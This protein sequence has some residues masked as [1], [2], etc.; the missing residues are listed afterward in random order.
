MPARPLSTFVLVFALALS[1]SA[2]RAADE[3]APR[4]IAPPS[5]AS[6]AAHDDRPISAPSGS[7]SADAI[8]TGAALVGVLALA[9]ILKK[10]VKR[11][12]DPL[13]ARRPSGVVRVLARFPLAKGQQVI[14]LEVGK[15][16]LC[17]HQGGAAATALCAFDDLTEIADLKARIEAGSADRVRFEHELTRSIERTPTREAHL[18]AGQRGAQVT[19]TIDLTKGRRFGFGFGGARA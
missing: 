2:A 11:L 16:V 4:P 19:E 5:A 15:R 1:S 7:L 12:G 10:L 17:V 6:T 3:T 13:A 14:L 8:R 9:L 18:S